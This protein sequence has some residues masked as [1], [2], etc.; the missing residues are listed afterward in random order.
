[1]KHHYIQ[2]HLWGTVRPTV[3]ETRVPHQVCNQLHNLC[4]VHVTLQR[5]GWHGIAVEC[6]K[7][8]HHKNWLLSTQKWQ[9]D[10]N[11]RSSGSEMLM[12][13]SYR[14]FK[15]SRLA[16]ASCLDV[17]YISAGPST[18]RL[19]LVK[20]GDKTLPVQNS[21]KQNDEVVKQNIKR[22]MGKNTSRLIDDSWY[23]CFSDTLCSLLLKD[24]EFPEIGVSLN[25]PFINGFSI[26]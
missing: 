17:S 10:P 21:H 25:H 8:W 15:I 24:M 14:K 12:D 26:V 19:H 16:A 20:C 18:V 23:S 7:S 22:L 9:R 1:M 5:M 4:K 3:M 2:D 11:F 6:I 13:H